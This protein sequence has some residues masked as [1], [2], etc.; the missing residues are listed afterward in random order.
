MAAWYPAGTI[1][2][3]ATASHFIVTINRTLEEAFEVLAAENLFHHNYTI[4][5]ATADEHLEFICRITDQKQE[6]YE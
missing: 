3:F 1:V 2:V 4:Y 5:R 6:N